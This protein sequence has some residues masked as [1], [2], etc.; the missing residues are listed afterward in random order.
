MD[1]KDYYKILGVD[2]SATQQEIK[3]AYRK[4]AAKY[5]PDKNPDD[6]TAETKFKEVG[7]AY[8]VLKDPEKRKL[9][10]RAGSDW[11]QYQQGGSRGGGG[12]DWNEYARQ[13]GTRQRVNVDYGDIFGDQSAGRGGA[14][15]GSP[16]SSFFETLFGGGGFQQQQTSRSTKKRSPSRSGGDTAANVTLPLK[17]LFTDTTK[18]FRINGDKVKIKIPGGI[19]DGKKLKLKGRG[20]KSDF[21]V[22]TGDLYL[23]IN[24]DIPEN[25]ER[26]GKDVY[27]DVDID[28]YTALLGGEIIVPTLNGKLKLNIPE[29]TENGKLFKF[30]GRG[31]PAMNNGGKKGNYYVRCNVK[32][33]KNLSS[34]EKKLL[35]E[36]ADI[37]KN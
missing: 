37:R 25:I 5:H 28:L 24:V 15:S 23:K 22:S 11:K 30:S 10:D 21:G 8:E 19:E 1:Y 35:K 34:R 18:T 16:F 12:F 13:Q 17:D 4:K 26:K 2:K 9:Y 6:S 31:L 29:E 20:S 7:E 32:L 3:K 27:Q 14:S 33:P 36:L